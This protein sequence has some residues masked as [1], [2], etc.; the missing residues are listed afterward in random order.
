MRKNVL[1]LFSISVLLI[2]ITSMAVMK[3]MDGY[4]GGFKTG[5]NS[6]GK[7]GAN[8][9]DLTSDFASG[10]G[11]SI[12]ENHNLTTADNS[13]TLAA[14]AEETMVAGLSINI[15]ENDTFA[16]IDED[17]NLKL[18]SLNDNFEQAVTENIDIYDYDL[19]LKDGKV[20]YIARD[21]EDYSDNIL[22]LYDI[23]TKTREIIDKNEPARI[24]RWSPNYKYIAVDYGTGSLGATKIYDIESKK[25]I[26]VTEGATMG[27]EWS[28]DGNS[29]T[30]GISE[31]VDPPTPIEEGDSIST[32]VV[33]MHKDSDMKILMKGSSEYLCQPVLWLDNDTLIIEK[34]M[35]Q[36][37]G[38]VQY[39]K[40]DINTSN[41]TEI[42]MEEIPQQEE[43]Q[44][45][46]DEALNVVYD[47]SSDGNN[48]L[49]TLY[50]EED[51]KLKIMVWD[52][53][54]QQSTEICPGSE[55]RWIKS[56]Q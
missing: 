12:A 29:I 46:P 13:E 24:V 43:P 19:N 53:E 56:K 36:G 52:V 16:Y 40:A 20:V 15:V 28:P 42:N 38:E 27:F 37:E 22:V 49:Y 35:V 6:K 30:I 14:S 23:K 44:N 39:Y 25:W 11:T 32:A 17:G 1:L 55:G 5:L 8:L 34:M 48:V 7:E 54:K 47:I 33:L 18:R 26:R 3:G 45:I 51:K 4:G 9:P 21:N 2:A 41:L 10:L 31:N 50:D